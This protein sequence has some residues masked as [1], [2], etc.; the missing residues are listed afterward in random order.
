MFYLAPLS[1]VVSRSDIARLTLKAWHIPSELV[2][3]VNPETEL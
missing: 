3:R 1:F 2:I